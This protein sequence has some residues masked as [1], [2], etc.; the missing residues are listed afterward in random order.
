MIRNLIALLVATG[1]C[2]CAPLS[3]APVALS[4]NSQAPWL[5]A[6]ARVDSCMAPPTRYCASCSA[7][8]GCPQN[9]SAYCTRGIDLD[10]AGGK[11]GSCLQQAVCSCQ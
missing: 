6:G 1:L 10:G 4:A 11:P 8:C 9:Q 2:A 7:Y 3:N 5:Q